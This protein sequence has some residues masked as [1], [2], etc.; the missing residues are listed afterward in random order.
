MDRDELEWL[1]HWC[2]TDG[3]IND[4]EFVEGWAT[5]LTPNGFD[6]F[7]DAVMVEYASLLKYG[8]TVG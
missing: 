1:A 3:N 8:I 5:D 7:V 4:P 6:L 2:V